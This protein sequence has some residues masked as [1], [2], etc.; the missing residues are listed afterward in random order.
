MFQKIGKKFNFQNGNHTTENYGNSGMKIKNGTEIS[1]ETFFRKSRVLHED[2]LFFG[3]YV[4]SQFSFQQLSF[5][6]RL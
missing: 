2:V 3:N 5:W 1:K 4:N 6:L